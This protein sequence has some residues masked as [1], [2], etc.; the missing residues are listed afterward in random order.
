MKIIFFIMIFTLIPINISADALKPFTS[1]G[2]S[3]FPDGTFKNN[4]L[5]W[6]CCY[7]HDLKYWQGGTYQQRLDADKELKIC[8]QNVDE[9]PI[10]L[11]MLVGVRIGGTPWLPT[12]F[13][14]GYGW[15]YPRFY[16]ELTPSELLQVK[17]MIEE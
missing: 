17:D 6:N 14:W 5:W 3:L 4:D 7:E 2:C 11:V 8:V 10:A 13:R 15:S 9:A 1:D 12:Y 16:G